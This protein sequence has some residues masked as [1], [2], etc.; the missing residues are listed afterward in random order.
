MSYTEKGTWVYLLA[1]LGVWLGYVAFL[2]QRRDGG[3]LDEV[4]YVGPLLW[5]VGISVL[6]STVGRVLFEVVRP[7]DSHL[8]DERDRDIDR[9]GEHVAGI[10]LGV[11]VVCP[12]ALA[13]TEAEHFW[14][15]NAIYAAYVLSAVVGSS[16]KLVGYRR[17][18]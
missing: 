13:L 3:P 15:A 1:S 14:I 9:R 12:L 11:A 17:G 4:A 16:V 2:L 5:S 8:A 10:V 18:V 6:A 7:S